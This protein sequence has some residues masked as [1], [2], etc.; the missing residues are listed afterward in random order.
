MNFLKKTRFTPTTP[1]PT[2]PIAEI[3]I[4]VAAIITLLRFHANTQ[5]QQERII[6]SLQEHLPPLTQ[7]NSPTHG[8]PD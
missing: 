2:I 7:C 5:S 8:F 4:M 6:L 3:L 1:S